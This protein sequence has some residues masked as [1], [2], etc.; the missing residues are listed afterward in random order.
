M[1]LT[2]PCAQRESDRR[3]CLIHE[4]PAEVLWGFWLHFSF[5]AKR[6]GPPPSSEEDLSNVE[7]WASASLPQGKIRSHFTVAK[8]GSLTQCNAS[9]QKSYSCTVKFV[10]WCRT[11]LVLKEFC[12]GGHEILGGTLDCNQCAFFTA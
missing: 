11:G 12:R 6:K 9:L 5:S 8:T 10:D 7:K 3:A 2:D 4:S 1:L